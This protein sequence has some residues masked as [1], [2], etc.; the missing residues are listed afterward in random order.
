MNGKLYKP[1]M[2]QK[3]SCSRL[4]TCIPKF[5]TQKQ[6]YLP[7]S[8]QITAD[9]NGIQMPEEREEGGGGGG[10]AAAAVQICSKSHRMPNQVISQPKDQES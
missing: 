10:A 5:I 7:Q 1:S 6:N 4:L 3:V 8:R 2:I 9:R